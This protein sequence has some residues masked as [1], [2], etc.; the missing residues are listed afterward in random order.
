MDFSSKSGMVVVLCFFGIASVLNAQENPLGRGFVDQDGDGHNDWFQDA[1]GDGVNDVDGIPYPHEFGYRDTDQDGH[2]DL[3][4]D[5]DGDGVNDRLSEIQDPKTDWVDRDGD[6]IRDPGRPLRGRAL[7]A[8]VLDT[9][10]DGVNDITQQ[11]Y[12]GSDLGGYQFGNIA[13]ESGTVDPD[14]QDLDGDGMND[15]F[16]SGTGQGRGSGRPMDHFMDLDGDGIA[17]DRGLGPFGG[18]GRGRGRNR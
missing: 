14:Y 18:A 17:D 7:K 5:A 15:H 6:G 13:E 11:R 16:Q 10:D 1:D 12:T 3:W 4:A 2:N 9:D 8:H